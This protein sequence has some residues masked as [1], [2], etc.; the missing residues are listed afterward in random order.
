MI[1]LTL[2]LLV[3]ITTI[4]CN[5]Q[6][7]S[8]AKVTTTGGTVSSSNGSLEYSAGNML[9]SEDESLQSGFQST[10]LTVTQI[11]EN[12]VSL[13]TFKVYP[14]PAA[15]SIIISSASSD[16]FSYSIYGIKGQIVLSE[17]QAL[18]DAEKIDISQVPNGTYF[19]NITNDNNVVITYQIVKAN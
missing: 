1:R 16:Y 19:I 14:N 8:P 11:T 15:Q 13:P 12:T 2:L 3:W 4:A 17:K 10:T 6:S 5:S 18:S 9:L 7:L